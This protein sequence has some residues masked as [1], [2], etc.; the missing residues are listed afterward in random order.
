MTARL[1]SKPVP[2]AR[3]GV[4]CTVFIAALT[5]AWFH[6]Y[7]QFILDGDKSLV[8]FAIVAVLAWSLAAVFAGRRGH[9]RDAAAACTM[10][11]F[12]GTLIGI[13]MGLS[14]VDVG[15]LTTP[16]G[17]IQAGT[18]LFGGIATAFCSTITGAVAAFWLACVGSAVG[19]SAWV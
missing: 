13:T 14:G 16:E 1:L 17:V 11:G 4:I 12:A 8:S 7:P 19:V 3:V 6:G 18:S 10:L 2:A 9:I 5:W 15:T